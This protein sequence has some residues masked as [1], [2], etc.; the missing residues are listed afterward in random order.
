MTDT[1]SS[2]K[3]F[4][5][6]ENLSSLLQSTLETQTSLSMLYDELKS[7]F[8]V[9][10]NLNASLIDEL[11]KMISTLLKLTKGVELF[12]KLISTALISGFQIKFMKGTGFAASHPKIEE[13]NLVITVSI[14]PENEINRD[15]ITFARLRYNPQTKN[16]F[17]TPMIYPSFIVLVHELVHAL[18]HMKWYNILIQKYTDFSRKLF[19]ENNIEFYSGKE[20]SYYIDFAYRI[21]AQDSFKEIFTNFP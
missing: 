6:V 9:D 21:I 1:S 19:D 13:E 7:V 15:K 10:P 14:I 18:H 11:N 2:E 4:L 3:Q 16:Y 20:S 12:E 17:F 8:K 5:L